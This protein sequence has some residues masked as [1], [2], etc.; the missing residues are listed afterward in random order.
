MSNES[1]YE[2]FDKKSKF[3]GR[4][5]RT[6]RLDTRIPRVILARYISFCANESGF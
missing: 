2:V 3:S 4:N 5:K 6:V 1:K